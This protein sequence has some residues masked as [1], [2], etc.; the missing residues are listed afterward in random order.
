MFLSLKKEGNSDTLL[1]LGCT[2]KTLCSAE[3]TSHMKDNSGL[4][5]LR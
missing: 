5:P 4:I 3:Y 1:Q 2:L